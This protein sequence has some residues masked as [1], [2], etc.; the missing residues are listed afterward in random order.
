[1][2]G[3][4]HAKFKHAKARG[5]VVINRDEGD[6][7]RPYEEKQVRKAVEAAKKAKEAHGEV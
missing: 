4:R 2:R 3:S 1:M 6:D 7:A 5:S